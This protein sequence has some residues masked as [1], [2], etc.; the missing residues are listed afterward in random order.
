MGDPLATLPPSVANYKSAVTRNAG[1]VRQAA[2]TAQPEQARIAERNGGAD[3]Q[4]GRFAANYFEFV[5]FTH[6]DKRRQFAQM[7]SGKESHVGAA[8]QNQRSGAA[9]YA[10]A[11]CST[12]RGASK[13]RQA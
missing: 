12:V 1:L 10:A 9:S 8:R 6:I 5:D 2:D 3:P 13:S 7:L 11:S 4:T